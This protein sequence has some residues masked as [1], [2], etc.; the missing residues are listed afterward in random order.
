MYNE[1]SNLRTFLHF[2]ASI[3]RKTVTMNDLPTQIGG[4]E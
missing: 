1:N 4:K 2:S 3:R